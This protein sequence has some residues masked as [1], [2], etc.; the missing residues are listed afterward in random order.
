MASRRKKGSISEPASSWAVT[1]C[2]TPTLASAVAGRTCLGVPAASRLS[3]SLAHSRSSSCASCSVAAGCRSVLGGQKPTTRA[4]PR[5]CPP[6]LW[7]LPPGRVPARAPLELKCASSGISCADTRTKRCAAAGGRTGEE[8]DTAAPA[9]SGRLQSGHDASTP[10]VWRHRP[11]QEAW[12]VWRQSRVVTCCPATNA[13]R[14]MEQTR[15]SPSSSTSLS[16]V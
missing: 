7:G 9:T 11:T 8:S 5:R 1:D 12:K 13:S 2:R 6:A 14:Q 10:F 16:S 15:H 3:P 4:S